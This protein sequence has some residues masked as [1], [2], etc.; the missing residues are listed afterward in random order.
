VG[1][2]LVIA[3]VA[4]VLVGVRALDF[5]VTV[6]LTVCAAIASVGIL[7]LIPAQGGVGLSERFTDAILAELVIAG[8]AAGL[9]VVWTCM[10]F[11]TG[12]VQLH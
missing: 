6:G 10:L 3:H 12:Q 2:V 11:V 4:A 5:G 9:L 7:T 8:I 1:A